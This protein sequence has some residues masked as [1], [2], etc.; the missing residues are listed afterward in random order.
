MRKTIYSFCLILIVMQCFCAIITC[1]GDKVTRDR[2]ENI[3]R[4][5]A[6]VKMIV[7]REAE[8]TES[9]SVRISFVWKLPTQIGSARDSSYFRNSEP[10]H[11]FTHSEKADSLRALVKGKTK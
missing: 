1:V 4:E 10:L 7:L 9:D 2:L 3:E 11:F 5:I 6:H 8:F